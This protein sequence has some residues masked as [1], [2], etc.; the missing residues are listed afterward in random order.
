[1]HKTI[2]VVT[3]LAIGRLGIAQEQQPLTPGE[4]AKK[5]DQQVTVQFQVRSSGGNRNRYLNSAASYEVP[6]NF[7]VF[8]PEAAVP[9]FVQAKIERPEEH[10]YGKMIQVTGTVTF[11]RLRLRGEQ[12]QRP[13]I[14]VTDPSQIKI[15]ES[16]SGPP[17][18]KKSHVYKRVG[19]LSIRADSYRFQ[20]R[21]GQPV[22]VWIH[23][24]ALMLGHRESVPRW[25][26]DAARENSWVVVSLDYRLAPETKLP[27]I[28][29]DIEDAF[30][31]IRTSGP[32]L[33]QADPARI[34]VAGSSA[35]GYLTLVTGYRVDPRPVALV[36]LWG[37]GDLI[38]PWYSQP[39]PHHKSNLTAAEAKEQTAGMPVSDDRDRQQAGA[40]QFYRYCRQHG[41]WPKIVSGWDPHTEADKFTPYMPLKNV[42]SS[43]PPTLLIHGDKDT[44]VPYEQSQLMTAELKKN[45]VEH[46]LITVAGA[47]HGLADA[48]QS[49]IQATYH[50][51][52]D[53]LRRHITH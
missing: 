52:V 47:E 24:G 7:T 35:G 37:Y 26:M 32:E 53:F 46:Q 4:A 8:I 30:R 5:I 23:G 19:S 45:G 15:V 33:F 29:S 3:M 25:L 39:S 9:A 2:L 22:V 48:S 51:A 36:S 11:F 38:G 1:M 14:S 13:Q 27:E 28:I 44:D 31:W 21:P 50:A 18:F 49:E 6:S 42:A 17:I 43:Y 41:L 20:D 10:Y 16:L 34:A 40:G 12:S